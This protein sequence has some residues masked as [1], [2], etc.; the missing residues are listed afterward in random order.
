[1]AKNIDKINRIKHQEK[2]YVYPKYPSLTN[3]QKREIMMSQSIE[4]YSNMLSMGGIMWG[5]CRLVDIILYLEKQNAISKEEFDTLVKM[6][7]SELDEDK[8][9]AFGIVQQKYKA[10]QNRFRI[11]NNG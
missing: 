3:K 2:E 1:M 10:Y 9:M 4:D 6:D 11:K 7:A 8:M 5:A